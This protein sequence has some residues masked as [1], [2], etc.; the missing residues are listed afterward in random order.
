MVLVE[1]RQDN[2]S[3]KAQ[4]ALE[5]E[6]IMSSLHDAEAAIRVLDHPV[7]EIFLLGD[8]KAE[9]ASVGWIGITVAG[10]LPLT[11]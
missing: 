9:R 5:M 7:E 10:A 6:R 2:L 8:V 3:L 1:K 11:L 4:N